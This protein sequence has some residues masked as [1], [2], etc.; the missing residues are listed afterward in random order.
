MVNV[1]N[2]INLIL[3]QPMRIFF[4]F[5]SIFLVSLAA[6]SQVMT[7]KGREFGFM[8]AGPKVGLGFSRISNAD[9]SF[10]GGDV[11]FRTG[12]E[13][14]IVGKFG[15]TDRLSIQPEITFMQRGV[16]TD[17][18]GFESKF[19]VSYL[20]IPVL[21][22]YSLK[23]LGFAKIHALGGVYSSVRT[24]G[25]VEFKDPGGTF[26]QKLDDSGWRRMDYGFAIGAGAELP[27]KNGTWVFDVRYDYSIV[28]VHK[29]DNTY[30]SNKTIGISV[31]YL[32]D[33]VDLYKRMRDKKKQENAPVTGN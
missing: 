3:Q 5:V 21:A 24:G 33:F 25:E 27:R 14:G 19:K 4:L 12:M 28:D 17:N 32:Y 26:T 10:G 29:S 22:K 15:I 11:K 13:L 31:T 30:N 1:V 23:A 2:C 7:I 20:N 6:S 18:N 9:K 16:Q 8:Y